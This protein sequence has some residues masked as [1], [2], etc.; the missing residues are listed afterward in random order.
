VVGRGVEDIAVRT[1]RRNGLDHFECFR[2]EKSRWIAGDQTRMVF[3]VDR[4]ATSGRLGQGAREL[5]GVEVEDTHRIPAGDINPAVD[6]VRRDVVKSSRRRE[7]AWWQESCR[8]WPRCRRPERFGRD[9]KTPTGRG[10]P[11]VVCWGFAP[12]AD[13]LVAAAD[14]TLIPRTLLDELRDLKVGLVSLRDGT[15]DPTTPRSASP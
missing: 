8:A 1:R 9:P 2:V 11:Q 10:R 3:R 4:D 12:A 13:R 7:S 14:L 6:A 5:V 15:L